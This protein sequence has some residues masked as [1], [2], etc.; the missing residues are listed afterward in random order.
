MRCTVNLSYCLFSEEANTL[1]TGSVQLWVYEMKVFVLIPHAW[2]PYFFFFSYK[3]TFNQLPQFIWV[4]HCCCWKISQITWKA[5]NPV[6]WS[7]KE[8]LQFWPDTQVRGAGRLSSTSPHCP[9][10]LHPATLPGT[11]TTAP[12][13]C[14]LIL[15]SPVIMIIG[16]AKVGRYL[17]DDPR[18]SIEDNELLL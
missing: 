13:S 18:E 10:L 9:S 2:L 6:W 11:A 7:C 14:I 16:L 17:I 15:L 1:L 3:K 5:T 8:Q 12:S 4:P